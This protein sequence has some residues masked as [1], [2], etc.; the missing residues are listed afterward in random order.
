MNLRVPVLASAAG[1]FRVLHL[2]VGGAGER[3]LVGHLRTADARLD[4][5]LALQPVDDDLQVQLA[6]ASDDDLARLLVGLHAERRILGHQLAQAHAELLLVCLGLRLDRQ[7]D[8]RL[9]EVHGFEDDRLALVAD[10]IAGGDGLQPHGG[11]N[12]ARVDFLDLFP[13]VRVHLQQPAQPLRLLLGRVVDGRAG[14]HDARVDADEGELADER[15]GHDL[16]SQRGERCAVGRLTLDDH[17]GPLIGVEPEDRR[18]IERRGQVVDHA[19][20]QRLHSLVL[21]RGSADDRHEGRLHLFSLR[22]HGAD[23]PIAQRPL[24]LLFGDLLPVQVLLE[25]LVVRLADLLDELLTVLLRLGQQVGGDLLDDVLGAHRLVLVADRLHLDEVDHAGELVLAADRQLDRDRVPAKLGRDLL[26]GALEVR[27]DAVHLVD[28]AD[29]GNAVLVGLTPH[30]LRLRLHAGNRVEHRDRAVEHA[31][32]PLHLGREVHV[33]GRVDDVDPDVAPET[34]GGGRRNRDAALLFLLHP[35]HRRRAF[36]H[37]ADL[38]RTARIEQDPFRRG[39][40]AGIDVGHDA[41]IASAA[42][43]CLSWH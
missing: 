21:E 40:L 27:P 37:L 9:G 3:L 12:V 19:V 2:A 18:N 35:V 15:V 25:E 16:E 23:D 26:E 14:R 22:V 28:E 20:E 17:L 24:D 34:G 13:L 32:R 39:G 6:H 1:L 11:G 43:W 41:D 5:E 29:P 31:E 4:V 7:R 30:R 38:V 33:T 36:V 42:E 8:D 10:R